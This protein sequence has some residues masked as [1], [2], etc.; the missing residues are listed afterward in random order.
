MLRRL[1]IALA[2]LSV[3]LAVAAAG[4]LWWLG[5]ESG[6]RFVVARLQDT[7]NAGPNELRI[8]GAS[9]N[10][11]RGVRIGK[12]SWH[13]EGLQVDATG[14]LARWSLPALLRR[15]ILIPELSASNLTVALARGQ[16][17]QA[18]RERIEMPGVIGL[19]VSVELQRLAVG[20]LR[21]IPAPA[22]ED[23]TPQPL[24]VTDIGARLA[25]R[26]GR[27]VVADL[28]AATPWGEATDVQIEFGDRPPH[29]LR[30]SLRWQGELVEVPLDL[31]LDAAGNLEHLEAKLAGSVADASVALAAKLA[32]LE[33]MPLSSAQ[34]NLAR[35]DLR[36]LHE[37]APQT[38]ID[39]ELSL[40]PAAAGGWAG[41][42]A[43]RNQS[44]GVLAEGKLPLLA[45]DTLLSVTSLE[46]P[47]TR[48]LQ[49][50]QLQLTLPTQPEMTAQGSISGS[51]D[52]QPGRT[53][54]VAGTSI[55]EVQAAL[56]FRAIDLAQFGAQLPATALDGKL[57][58]LGSTFAL[59]LAQP[60]ERI[61]ALMPKSLAGAAGAAEVALR[62]RLEA[63]LLHLEEARLQLGETS[64][65][66]SGQVGLEG[67]HR[68]ALKGGVRKFDL[69]RWLPRNDAIDERWR[70]GR[71]SGDWSIDGTVLPGLDAWLTLV[72]AQ[73]TLAGEPLAADVKSRILLS[74]QWAPVR[75]ERMAL[76]LRL[77]R[78]RAQA[79]G[80]LGQ[81][82]DKLGLDL[83]LPEPGLLDP[84]LAGRITLAGELRG[85]FDRLQARLVMNGERLAFDA[86]GGPLRA[87]SVRIEAQAPIT[88]SMPPQA[89]ID[90]TVRLRGLEAARKI[91]SLD[92]A[93]NGKLDAH[94]FDLQAVSEG[95]ALKMNGTAQA[96]LGNDPSWQARLAAARLDGKV[97]IR[98][99]APAEIRLNAGS[100]RVAG[101]KVAV[102]GGSAALEH[103]LVGWGSATSFDTRGGVK[104]VP[105]V[106]L[107]ALAGTDPGYDFLG[108]LRLDA[109]WNLKGSS[110]EDLSGTARVDL[111]EDNGAGAAGKS[112]AVASLGLEG[113]NGARLTFDKG[114]LDGRFDLRLPSLAFTQPLTAPDLVI[115]GRMRLAGSVAGTLAQPSFNADLTGENLSLLQ[116]SVG[117]RLSK[118]VLAARFDGRTVQLQKLE[119]ASGEGSVA[120]Q[121]QASLLDKP[122]EPRAVATAA[123]TAG[124]ATDG[125][126]AAKDQERDRKT[127]PASVAPFNGRFELTASRLEV[128]LGPGQ[129][130][131]VSGATRL[132][133]GP[134]GLSLR[135]KLRA[136][137]GTIE[138]QG[139]SAPALP[140]DVKLVYDGPQGK[141]IV[142]GRGKTVSATP[143]AAEP[144]TPTSRIRILTDLAVDLGDRLRVVGNG[145]AARLG[146]QLQVLGTLPDQPRLVGVV[147]IIEGSY[148]AYGQN[149]RI[150]KGAAIRFNGP[151]DN[152]ALDLVAKRPFLP[153]EVGVAISGTVRDPVITLVSDQDMSD[154]DKL[155]WL[156]LGTDPKN[157][158]NAAQSLA[159]R[160][161]GR[162]LL[163]KDDGRHKPGV[164]ERL[165]FDVMNFGYG[166][167]TGAPQGITA[168]K[169]PTGLP[170]MQ[171]GTSA[172]STQQEVVTLGKRIGTRLFV[173]YERG[174][175]GVYDLLRIQYALS[176][177]LALRAQSGSDNAVDLLYSYSFD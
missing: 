127:G 6:L 155:S 57:R 12:L 88:A 4:G 154:T 174:V 173:S 145:V 114:R 25:Y 46:D 119:F 138:I 136:D 7:M 40:A 104:D 92:L 9:G 123:A 5:S 149:L 117:W 158:P 37:A 18:P 157:A 89:P 134:E 130:V 131:T 16:P 100:L 62:G 177:R 72:L 116:R 94:R 110:P 95:Q 150:E 156:V 69:A 75:F 112:A 68:I 70:K 105:I 146:G 97:P 52:V 140:D 45:L 47:A 81:G 109:D 133:S 167:D 41:R 54:T 83:S 39:A 48:R 38:L 1:L 43:L 163:L 78:N 76:D 126:G 32:P 44:S 125:R 93:V 106:R 50:Q 152:P 170:G 2:A 73:S 8:E 22:A 141:R 160:Q 42:L 135:G 21:V 142:D 17:D 115:D 65:H 143:G 51:V 121:G 34:A 86:P 162:S 67:P 132:E 19:P 171:S 120:L 122:R 99:T 10:L 20:E 26:D 27:F 55:P 176:Q 139:S 118:G 84:R 79:T 166:S 63:S 151:V 23:P 175:D 101:F 56:D 107:L 113:S 14:V 64:L 159:L 148:Q 15:Q 98:L 60:A 124:K 87:G 28:G 36:R 58:L 3:L 74:E 137:Q 33:P 24:I 102:A 103:L 66:T 165:G 153:V 144:E 128:P 59:D 164:A 169:N 71:I 172:S 82:G 85:A 29:P 129:R 77:G 53:I 49:L 111:R 80:S 147:N 96:A 13:G 61:R 161:A 31:R 30:A 90:V 91:E 168:S 35:L 108:Q 11:Y